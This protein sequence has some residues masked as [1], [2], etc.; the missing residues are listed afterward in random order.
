MKGEKEEKREGGRDLL[1]KVKQVFSKVQTRSHKGIDGWKKLNFLEPKHRK[2]YWEKTRKVFPKELRKPVKDSAEHFVEKI[3]ARYFYFVVSHF[4]ST[5]Y[6][7]FHPLIQSFL[8][9]TSTF[10]VEIFCSFFFMTS[11]HHLMLMYMSLN[12][13]LLMT[14]V[15]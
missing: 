12:S 14:S 2:S 15:I 3:C 4:L 9:K 6:D 1:H 7:Q 11:M 8:V 13:L 5:H 10:S